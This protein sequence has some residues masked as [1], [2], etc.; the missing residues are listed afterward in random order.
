[1]AFV[2][3][4][5]AVGNDRPDS[6]VDLMIVADIDVF[7]LGEA[8]QRL[9]KAL[10]RTIDLNIHTPEEW[11][12]LA[13]DRVVRSRRKRPEDYSDGPLSIRRPSERPPTKVPRRLM[14]FNLP[15]DSSNFVRILFTMIGFLR[16]SRIR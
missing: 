6:D 15:V 7:D 16:I 13:D 11:A 12:R 4:S 8:V 2:F 14:I 10:G 1:M 3:G 5:V 9:E